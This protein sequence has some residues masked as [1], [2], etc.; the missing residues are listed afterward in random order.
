MAVASPPS[1]KEAN[2]WASRS[3]LPLQRRLTG[4]GKEIARIFGELGAKLVLS[5]RRKEVL[6]AAAVELRADTGAEVLVIPTNVREADQV[7]AMAEQAC[8]HF[9]GVDILVNN[10]GANF[11]AP[12]AS[13]SPNGWRSILSTIL[14]GTFYCC[15]YVG[16]RMI[17]RKKGGT[18]ISIVTP[19][20]ETGA[21]GFLPSC[22][23]KA[24]VIALTKT[25][26]VEWAGSGIN[27]LAVSPGAVDS[28]GAGQRLWPTPE[29]RAKV[30]RDIPAGRM[31]SQVEV[32]RVVAFL[33]SPYATFMNGAIVDM[34][35]GQN[36]GKGIL[37][38]FA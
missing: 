5:G 12:A 10:A 14:D 21:P 30:L 27:V 15:R 33:C 2:G 20:A 8:A 19:Y 11:I 36:L 35:G 23:G 29:D 38:A 26:A 16:A 6:D 1:Q 3:R 34:D 4:I 28:E 7:Q 37:S 32:A 31:A 13:I 25:L 17:D 18:I 24:G 9:G 22:V